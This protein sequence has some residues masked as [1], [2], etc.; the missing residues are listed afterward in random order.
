MG[1]SRISYHKWEHLLV[2][3]QSVNWVMN[4]CFKVD[5]GALIFLPPN[6]NEMI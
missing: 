4:S 2:L 5:L 1:D 6:T 3:V